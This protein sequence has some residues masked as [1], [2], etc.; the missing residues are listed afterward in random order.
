M[1]DPS[2]VFSAIKRGYESIHRLQAFADPSV[3]WAQYE[4]GENPL[5]RS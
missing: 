1:G 3:G 2:V 5:F 4:A